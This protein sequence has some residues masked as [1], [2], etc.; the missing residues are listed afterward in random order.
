MQ[1]ARSPLSIP[2]SGDEDVVT[3]QSIGY[4]LPGI[5]SY[6]DLLIAGPKPCV[7]QGQGGPL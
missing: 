7:H 1:S 2:Y 3:P 6:M 5:E 4:H